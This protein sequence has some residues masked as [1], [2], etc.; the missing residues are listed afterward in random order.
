MTTTNTT[1]NTNP[2]TVEGSG[3]YNA[4]ADLPVGAF[5]AK[6]FVTDTKVYVIVKRTAKTITVRPASEGERRWSEPSA[7][8]QWPVVYTEQVAMSDEAAAEAA[9]HSFFPIDR[10]CRI[11]KLGQFALDGGRPF[12]PATTIDG[13]AVRRTDYSY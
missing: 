5:V 11:N 3:D 13:V 8:P 12:Y 10:T 4:V 6:T 7:N 2:F 1:P 9:K